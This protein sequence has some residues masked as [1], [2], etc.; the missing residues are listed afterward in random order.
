V[1]KFGS[2]VVVTG[3]TAGALAVVTALAIQAQGSVRQTAPRPTAAATSPAKAHSSTPPVPGIPANSGTGK[4]VVYSLSKHRVWLVLSEA[5]TAERTFPVQASA[6]SPR[7][8]TYSVLSE[9]RG[10]RKGSDG[11]EIQDV[12]IFAQP[13]G[14]TVGFSSAVD[15]SMASPPPGLRT[16]GIREAPA[17]GKALYA[18]LSIGDKIVVVP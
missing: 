11:V 5:R 15:G 13:S 17:D 12:V 10:P 9:S 1:A 18:F 16:G 6:V 14:V 8:G 3:L 4:R 2:G 7:P